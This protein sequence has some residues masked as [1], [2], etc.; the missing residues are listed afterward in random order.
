MRNG[1][2]TMRQ[3]YFLYH[4]IGIAALAFSSGASA[5]NGRGVAK[6]S[7]SPPGASVYIEGKEYG[8]TPVF[9]EL[10]PGEYE[11]MVSLDGYP[12]K[13]KRL[14]VMAGRVSYSQIKFKANR[15]SG[16]RV[17]DTRKN[18][19]DSGPGTVNIATDPPGLSIRM[20]RE[21]VP[22]ETPVSF[23]VR[24]G[25]YEMTVEKNGQ[26]LLKKTIF[27]RAGRTLELDFKVKHRR[28]IDEDDPWK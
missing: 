12:P 7:S 19:P 28:Q 16:I 23:D 2:S 24:A 20:N 9:I 6:V 13:K 3:R 22:K 15:A 8:P 17:H 14:S 25:A 11:M 26:V 27:V 5:E 18:G 4:F 21:L 1:G 10:T